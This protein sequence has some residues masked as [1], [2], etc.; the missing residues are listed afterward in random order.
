[1]AILHTRHRRSVADIALALR[2]GTRITLTRK[3]LVVVPDGQIKEPCLRAE[4]RWIPICPSL[5]AR[6]HRNSPFWLRPERGVFDRPAVLVQAGRP[7]LLD[8]RLAQQ[9]LSGGSVQHVEEA[10]AVGPQHHFAWF[11]LPVDIREYGN[12][13]GVPVI[14]VAGRELEIP[15]QLTGVGIQRHHRF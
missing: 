11:A 3:G 2:P 8:E 12:L 4:G 14:L 1:M 13:G 9:E 7:G 15:L 10:V 6:H 5:R